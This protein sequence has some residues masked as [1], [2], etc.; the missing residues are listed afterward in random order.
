M[1]RLPPWIG[2]SVRELWLRLA[3]TGLLGYRHRLSPLGF[4]P[5]P[6]ASAGQTILDLHRL[7][8]PAPGPARL[9]SHP[10]RSSPLPRYPSI[11]SWTLVAGASCGQAAPYRRIQFHTIRRRLHSPASELAGRFA[12]FPHITSH[13]GHFVG[14]LLGGIL[15]FAADPR[16]TG[17]GRRLLV[18]APS[19][20]WGEALVQLCPPGSLELVL[21]ERLLEGPLGL[22]DALL[23]PRL[24]PWQ[25]LSLARDL[26]GCALEQGVW[27]A[28]AAEAARSHPD[29]KLLL[30]SRR[31]E[32]IANLDEV[33]AVFERH[34]YTVLD[35]VGMAIPALLARLRNARR[36]WCEHGSL[37][38]HALLCRTR[39]YRLLEL[40]RTAHDPA[41]AFLGGGLYNAFQRALIRPFPCPPAD[42]SA[43]LD[44]R[45]HPYQRQLR[46]DPEALEA[47]LSGECGPEG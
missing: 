14:D 1:S 13:F 43:A 18:T 7:T 12:V 21:P 33:L 42:R 2:E 41:A 39:P 24:S 4:G 36:L 38:L 30:T 27:A 15:W 10:Y 5:P 29:E 32:R 22:A 35:P 8:L 16:V 9:I 25:N 31:P 45:V 40:E 19:S 46:L 47:A 26:I 20:A 23:L 44:R 3:D 6:A 28:A 11:E 17:E 34:G 37:V